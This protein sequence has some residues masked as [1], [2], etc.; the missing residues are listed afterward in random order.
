[1]ND[2][3]DVDALVE[4]LSQAHRILVFTGAGISTASNI[5]DYRGP[6]GVWSR[7]EPVYYQD[8]VASEES[9][10]EYWDYKLEGYAVFR[11]AKP[12]AAHHAVVRLERMNRVECVVTQNID[13]LHQLAGTPPARLVELH[14]TGSQAECLECKER[15]PIARPMQEFAR[16]RRPPRCACGGL[17]KPAVIMF[18]QPLDMAELGR[19]QRASSSADLVLVLGSSLVVTP[20]A[21][22]P[23][24]AVRRGAPYVIINRGSTPHDELATLRL[25]GDVSDVFPRAVAAL[26]TV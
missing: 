24:F 6:T 11:D 23:L 4:L 15:E 20:A 7:R 3:S 10:I 21:D 5:P 12:N 22:V 19:A 2:A 1:M 16:T 8:F 18:G 9:Q 26:K 25:D 17:L 13:G 14:G